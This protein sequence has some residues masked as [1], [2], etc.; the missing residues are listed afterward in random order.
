MK[1]KLDK[2]AKRARKIA[3]RVKTILKTSAVLMADKEERNH[4]EE[5]HDQNA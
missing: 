2:E 3:S 4:E 1:P 5:A